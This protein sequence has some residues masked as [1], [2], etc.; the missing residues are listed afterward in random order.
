MSTIR[1]DRDSVVFSRRRAEGARQ[2][3]CGLQLSLKEIQAENSGLEASVRSLE[4]QLAAV[5]RYMERTAFSLQPRGVK[6]K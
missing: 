2:E 4:S 3:L 5:D 6:R 1:V